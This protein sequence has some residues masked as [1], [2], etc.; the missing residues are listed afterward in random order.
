MTNLERVKEMRSRGFNSLEISTELGL[1]L[2]VTNRLFTQFVP[3][4]QTQIDS[5]RYTR[6]DN[7]KQR[8]EALA[9]CAA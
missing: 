8:E 9:K 5:V 6:Y 3:D 4:P 2:R 1:S 7:P